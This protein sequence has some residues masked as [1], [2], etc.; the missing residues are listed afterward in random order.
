MHFPILGL[1]A[2]FLTALCQTAS[3]I[4]AKAATREAEQRLI[5]AT[6]WLAGGLLLTLVCLAANPELLRRPLDDFLRADF[7]PTLVAGGLLNLVAHYFYVRAFRLSDA[8]LVAPVILLTP[9]LLLVTS[10]LMLGEQVSP[11]GGVGVLLSVA[12]AALLGRR[13]AGAPLAASF[14]AL[15]SDAGVRS[16]FVTAVLWSITANMDKIGVR[17]S[18][19]L[20]WIAALSDFIAASAVLF[21]L[22]GPRQPF[23]LW[24][25][26]YA[27]ASGAANA[28]GNALQM[29]AL[30]LLFVPYV[31]AIKRLSGLFTVLASSLIFKEDVR[32]RLLAAFIMLMGAALIAFAR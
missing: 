20:I 31:I 11:L 27:G 30:T 22:A 8:S 9:V 32:D 25:T 12:G 10:P 26:R 6:Q 16:M 23:S 19:P 17:A 13:E 2:A 21:Y 4:G 5:L 15:A 3:D 29:Y 24:E 18:S 14:G 7:Y 1:V 28:I